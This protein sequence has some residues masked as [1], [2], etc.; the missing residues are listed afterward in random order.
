MSLNR[1]KEAAE[2]STTEAQMIP[3]GP[4]DKT[5]RQ[6][7]KHHSKGLKMGVGT[8]KMPVNVLS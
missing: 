8:R 4:W 1:E 2:S 7:Q 6:S 5:E 3:S